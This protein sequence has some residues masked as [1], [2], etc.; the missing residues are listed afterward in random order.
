MK[1]KP[2][3]IEHCEEALEIFDNQKYDYIK[4]LASLLYYTEKKKE[5]V[6]N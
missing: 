2:L 4:V 6:L 1:N 5:E 3:S